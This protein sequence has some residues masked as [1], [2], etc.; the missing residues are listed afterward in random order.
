M[1]VRVSAATLH[2]SRVA[3]VILALLPLA[4]VGLF[5][6]FA[7]AATLG[8]RS[9]TLTSYFPN[10]TAGYNFS[11]TNVTAGTIGSIEFELCSNNPLIG[12]ACTAP[13]GLD[14]GSASLDTQTGLTGFTISPASTANDIILTRPPSAAPAGNDAFSLGN[15]VNPSSAGTYYARLMVYSSSDASGTPLDAGGVAFLITDKYSVTAEV[16]PYLNFCT[17]VVITG[18]DCS[19]A[20]GSYL[21]FGRLTSSNTA[22]AQS[23][24]LVATNAGNGYSI[25]YYGTT[26]TSGNNVIPALATPDI[27][28]PGTSQFGMNLVVNSDP[29]VGSNVQGPGTGMPAAD[30]AEANKYL[31]VPGDVLASAP[32]ADDY[33]KYSASYIINISKDQPSGIYVSTIN[34]VA[35]ANF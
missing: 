11:F 14:A 30:Y 27:S 12:T 13:A 33:R 23:Q 15:V 7:H 25:S 6:L 5:I 22:S 21:N 16:P 9:L 3:A 2:V 26:L 4:G 10:A 32:A 28:R 31:F 18:Y 19:N 24:L 34:Y 17:A 29:D 1:A 20:E 8:Y 35:L